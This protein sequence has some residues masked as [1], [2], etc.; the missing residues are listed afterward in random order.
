MKKTILVLAGLTLSLSAC[1]GNS[2]DD[3][4]DDTSVSTDTTYV[5]D[6]N[7]SDADL[8][9]LAESICNAIGR[10]M[11]H[12]QAYA[13]LHSEKPGMTV[14][15]ADNII[16]SAVNLGCPQYAGSW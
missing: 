12:A 5:P 2:S 8:N 10:G 4:S 15:Q 3:S 11:S 7:Y 16:H 13:V 14:G 6:M 9:A 1:A